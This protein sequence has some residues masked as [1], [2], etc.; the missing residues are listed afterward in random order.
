[1]ALAEKGTNKYIDQVVAGL[2]I[3]APVLAKETRRREQER[4]AAEAKA[5]AQRDGKERPDSMA[6]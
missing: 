4:E 5:E 1:M 6:E 2:I 3:D